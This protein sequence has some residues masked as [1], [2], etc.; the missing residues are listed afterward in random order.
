MI[1]ADAERSDE[2]TTE[3][4]SR[5][6]IDRVAAA[7]VLAP[8]S[9]STAASVIVILALLIISWCVAYLGGGAARMGTAWFY[10]PIVLAAARF[11]FPGAAITGLTASILAGPWMPA[12]VAMDIPQHALLNVTR[13]TFYLL[14]GLLIAA[15][16]GRLRKSLEQERAVLAEER[17]LAARKA[18][19][20]STVS[21]EFRTPLSV[22]SGTIATLS[23]QSLSDDDQQ[24]LLL[25]AQD[26]TKKLDNLVSGILAVA[27]ERQPGA[28][29]N[30]RLISVASVLG[31]VSQDLSERYGERI[32]FD[33]RGVLIWA[34]PAIVKPA[35]RAI[36]DNALKFS[37]SGSPVHVSAA[38]VPGAAEITVEDAGPGV[39]RAF[40]AHAFEAFTQADDS[41]TREHGGLGMGLFVAKTLVSSAGGEIALTSGGEGTVATIRLPGARSDIEKSRADADEPFA[42]SEALG[43]TSSSSTG[44]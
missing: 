30:T 19:V 2:F 4:V 44:A 16:V 33:P 1:G 41:V 43:V 7:V 42:L 26:S 24:R 6:R 31:E 21:H 11:G 36:I 12:D 28:R 10:F 8:T 39:E 9:T 34:D 20:I 38:R 3:N 32:E 25:S 27:E 15:I 40:L 22:I 17:D 5:R 35:F 23:D 37:P 14:I 13:A 29:N 18:A